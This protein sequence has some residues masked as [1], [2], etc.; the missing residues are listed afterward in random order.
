[1]I[2]VVMAYDSAEPE[3]ARCL[4]SLRRQKCAE[5]FETLVACP[6]E[7]AAG[8]LAVRFPEVRFLC[9]GGGHSKPQLLKRALDAAR[10]EIVAVTEPYCY[11]PADWVG[12]LRRAHKGDFGV[13]G[14]AVEYGG[15]DT[16]VGWACHLADYGPFLL[17]AA[18]RVTNLL[19]GGHISYKRGVLA[20]AAESWKEGYAK[21]F[22]L[23]DL[24]RR[25][26]RCL[27]NSELVVWCAPQIGFAAFARRYYRDAREFAA[28][29]V[30]SLSALARI[31]RIVTA[32]ALPAILLLRRVRAVWGKAKCRVRL[33]EALPL[34][35]VFVLCWSAGELRGYLRYD[36]H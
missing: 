35:A 16:L 30:R 1:V 29:R 13:I 10:G 6:S 15:P 8:P 20:Q 3:L 32:P 22:V 21:V 9:W 25:G 31:A 33:M 27:F 19:A 34:L 36:R 11:F 23:W 5:Q 17:P 12:K 7:E 24:Q 26:I 14:G 4:E 28:T 18:S 2:S